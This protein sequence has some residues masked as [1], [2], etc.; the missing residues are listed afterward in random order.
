MP[1]KT[2][3]SLNNIM[4][5]LNTSIL[6]N[7]SNQDIW[8]G[9]LAYRCYSSWVNVNGK[10]WDYSPARS[11]DELPEKNRVAWI[12]AVKGICRDSN[13]KFSVVKYKYETVISVNYNSL[14]QA[15]EDMEEK[16]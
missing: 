7:M 3:L 16:L 2:Y 6:E 5:N 10:A 15:I 11:F 12:M 8:N 4:E 9:R 14:V 13:G 1:F